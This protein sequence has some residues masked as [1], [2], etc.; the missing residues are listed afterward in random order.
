[1]NILLLL[2]IQRKT[3]SF[4]EISAKFTA[5]AA[6]RLLQKRGAVSEKMVVD[7]VKKYAI[8][9]RKLDPMGVLGC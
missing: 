8:D 6:L 7:F 1:L 2:S 9:G 5:L 3:A 4:F